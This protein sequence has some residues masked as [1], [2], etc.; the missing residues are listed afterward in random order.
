MNA[1]VRD[2]LNYLFAG[3]TG[4]ADATRVHSLADHSLPN[5]TWDALA[6]N[7]TRYDNNSNMAG[8]SGSTVLTFPNIGTYLLVAQ[9][10]FAASQAGRRAARISGAASGTVIAETLSNPDQSSSFAEEQ[11]VTTIWKTTVAS[12]QFRAEA[13]QDSGAAL[14]SQYVDAHAF[15]YMAVRIA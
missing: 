11:I 12:Q 15:E 5:N 14:T 4:G 6:Y 13:F 8:S 7:A 1:H 10:R 3:G 9:V 2:N